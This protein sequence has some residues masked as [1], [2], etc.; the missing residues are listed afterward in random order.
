MTERRKDDVSVSDEIA[1][2]EREAEE[3]LLQRETVVAQIRQLREAEDPATGTYYAQEIFRLSQDKLRLATEAELC[4]CKA[5]RLRLGNK[6][7]G[8]VQ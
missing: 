5:N 7:T 3:I 8:I 1:D 2:L 4:K 6:P